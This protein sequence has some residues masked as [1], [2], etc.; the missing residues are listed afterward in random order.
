MFWLF[1]AAKRSSAPQKV[2]NDLSNDGSAAANSSAT[3]LVSAHSSKP[4]P[5]ATS[6]PAVAESLKTAAMTTTTTT[7]TTT[8]G[9][10]THS[11]KTVEN[12][13]TGGT[14]RQSVDPKQNGRG[15]HDTRPSTTL[16]PSEKGHRPVGEKGGTHP[17]EKGQRISSNNKSRVSDQDR[18]STVPSER[19]HRLASDKGHNVTKGK[20][21]RLSDDRVS[22]TSDEGRKPPSTP[23]NVA[24]SFKP[25]LP[26]SHKT[27]ET[28]ASVEP[29][30]TAN[31][32]ENKAQFG[33]CLC[34]PFLR[35]YLC[36]N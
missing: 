10:Q 6:T 14:K 8:T 15:S 1:F 25:D 21:H 36:G 3:P 12:P 4:R 32:T 11:A 22:L 2:V 34:K 17:S 24:T 26:T 20:H 7:H 35:Q 31:E 16:P 19:G 23:E 30:E 18:G 29:H 33:M 27:H 9:T 13:N 5:P 28:A